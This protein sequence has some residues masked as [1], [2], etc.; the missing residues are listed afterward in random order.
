MYLFIVIILLIIYGI[1]YETINIKYN[2]DS[3]FVDKLVTYFIIIFL[4]VTWKYS[5]FPVILLTL[6][7]VIHWIVNKIIKLWKKK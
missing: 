5:L 6:L 3:S 1:V 2:F 4:A 7:F